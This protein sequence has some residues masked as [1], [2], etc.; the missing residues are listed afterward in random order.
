[1]LPLAREAGTCREPA[2]LLLLLFP[3]HLRGIPLV[4]MLHKLLRR[5]PYQRLISSLSPDPQSSTALRRVTCDAPGCLGNLQSPCCT[6]PSLWGASMLLSLGLPFVAP[7]APL[8][9]RA[10]WPTPLE[11]GVILDWSCR[12]L[13]GVGSNY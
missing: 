13:R 4:F 3:A 6:A 5:A 2:L 10:M 11:V 7:P 12:I 9:L 1:M 8:L